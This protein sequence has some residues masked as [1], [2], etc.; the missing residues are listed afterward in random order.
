MDIQNIFNS[1]TNRQSWI[2][3]QIPYRTADS[4]MKN[5]FGPQTTN[6]YISDTND[7]G[8][9]YNA[10]DVHFLLTQ[11]KHK[12]MPILTSETNI[13]ST[14]I[15]DDKNELYQCLKTLEKT[16]KIQP[17]VIHPPVVHT[18][19]VQPLV[20]SFTHELNPLTDY[21]YMLALQSRAICLCNYLNSNKFYSKY[22][23]N[24]QLLKNNLNKT[25]Y[26]FQRLE[27]TDSDIAYVINKG[28]E[29]KFRVRDINRYVP[30]NVYQY[31]LYHEMAHMST[32]EM[33]HTPTFYKLMS[34]IL[35]A[36]FENGFIKFENLPNREYVSDGQPIVSKQSIK[37]EIIEGANLI[38]DDE[39]ISKVY[40]E[41][42]LNYLR[43]K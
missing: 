2:Q 9:S 14:K 15:K 21:N 25:N 22:S 26:L 31:V 38:L 42:I 35:F 13:V 16:K 8:L 34:I 6:S 10:T 5:K 29:I 4:K 1:E 18:P 33:Q 11:D 30:L 20:E 36:A 32:T 24:W 7:I 12:R 39:K 19:S 3:H 23:Y 37:N 27:D 40:K 28:E 41:N 17:L 43:K